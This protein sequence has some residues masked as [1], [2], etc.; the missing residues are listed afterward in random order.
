MSKNQVVIY[1]YLAPQDVTCAYKKSLCY[2]KIIQLLGPM[3][4]ESETI[5]HLFVSDSLQPHGL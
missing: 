1:T 5:S 2:H 3:W 4:K